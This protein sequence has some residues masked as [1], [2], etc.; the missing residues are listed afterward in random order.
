MSQTYNLQGEKN[1]RV[2]SKG[3]RSPPRKWHVATTFARHSPTCCGSKLLH[4]PFSP[5]SGPLHSSKSSAVPLAVP[6]G[7]GGISLH[8]LPLMLG[9]ARRAHG[10]SRAKGQ[11][12]FARETGPTCCPKA[13]GARQVSERADTSRIFG[14]SEDEDAAAVIVLQPLQAP[15]GVEV[16]A[17]AHPEVHGDA[18]MFGGVARRVVSHQGA[19]EHGHLPHL[20]LCKTEPLA[21]HR[22]QTF[23]FDSGAPPAPRDGNPR[24][25]A[26][27]PPTEWSSCCSR[28]TASRSSPLRPRK[29]MARVWCRF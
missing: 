11:K 26:G 28:S 29:K 5:Y 24:R 15:G 2:K 3:A 22:G 20:S 12:V 1:I 4:D 14:T 27:T 18:Q 19:V 6:G 25:S 16:S 17:D 7:S 9:S 23:G 13:H 10:R 21:T 8:A